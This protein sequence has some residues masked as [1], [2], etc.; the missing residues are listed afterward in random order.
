MTWQHVALA[1]AGLAALCYCGGN[2]SCNEHFPLIAVC[3]GSV[4]G[5]AMGNAGPAI[6]R[7]FGAPGKDK[8]P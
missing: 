8:E 3:A 2:P 4:I 6:F 1:I 7:M 5:G